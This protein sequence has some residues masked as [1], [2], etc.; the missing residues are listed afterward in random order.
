MDRHTHQGRRVWLV[1]H[2][3]RRPSTL[4]LRPSARRAPR[5][6]GLPAGALELVER[7]ETVR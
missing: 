2:D 3:L 1:H 4:E 6:R 5:R 7:L